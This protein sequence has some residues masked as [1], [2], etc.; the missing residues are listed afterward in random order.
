MSLLLKFLRKGLNESTTLKGLDE[1]IKEGERAIE[2]NPNGA[3][4]HVNMAVMLYF[5]GKSAP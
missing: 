3:D 2:L 5:S 4:S 1:A